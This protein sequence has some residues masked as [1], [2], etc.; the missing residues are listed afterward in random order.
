[1]N[2]KSVGLSSLLIGR[3]ISSLNR[4]TD[5]YKSTCIWRNHNELKYCDL[6]KL[7]AAAAAITMVVILVVV[8]VNLTTSSSEF[9]FNQLLFLVQ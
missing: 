1:M 4:R 6:F 5:I 7:T 8:T 2:L 9:Y 3:S